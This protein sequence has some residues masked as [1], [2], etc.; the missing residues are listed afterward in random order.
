MSAPKKSNYVHSKPSKQNLIDIFAGEWSSKLPSE[1]SVTTGAVADLF[2]DKRILWAEEN[3]ISFS[4]KTI[5]ELGPLEGGH[6]WMMEQRGAREIVAIEAHE[7]AFLKCLIIKE[8]A[9]LKRTKFLHGDFE[10]Y[11]ADK[12]SKYDICLASGVLYH[13]KNPSDLLHNICKSSDKL[14][15]WTHY[16]DETIISENPMLH[17]RFAKPIVESYK[18]I[19]IKS[20]P[21]SYYSET[22]KDA[23]CGG[24]NSGS[25]WLER[26]SLES[27][28]ERNDFDLTTGFDHPHHPN[29]PA[30]AYLGIKK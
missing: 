13:S 21:Y 10:K 6:T 8:I 9:G 18:G 30:I 4:G 7:R 28:L 11:L 16:Y 2:E 25:Q 29:G 17:S 26:R 12:D 15:L 23:F 1:W 24:L 20:Y 5:L 27:I 19:E 22:S 3:G 14:I